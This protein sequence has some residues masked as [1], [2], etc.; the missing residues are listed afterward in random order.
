MTGLRILLVEDD[1]ADRR[2]F[3]EL[4]RESG[5]GDYEVHPA[6]RVKAAVERLRNES[7][8]VVVTDLSLPDGYGRDTVESLRTAAPGVPIIVLTGSEHP[9][10]STTFTEL[11]IGIYVPKY[12]LTPQ[13]LQETLRKV[14]R[15]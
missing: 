2:L 11:N 14:V 6:E 12:D 1:P 13:L 8:D 9:D 7:F 4:L 15:R 5:V 10:L 3:E